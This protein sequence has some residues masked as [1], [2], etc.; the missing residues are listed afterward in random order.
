MKRYTLIF[1]F[2]IIAAVAILATAYS[3]DNADY[4]G[5][6]PAGYT[7]SPF[8][9]K[10]CS[11]C[12]GGTASNVT[13]WITSNVPGTGYVPGNNY[14]ITVTVSG[15]GNKGFEV[16]PQDVDG[17]L[18]GTLI[19]GPGTEL[20]GSGKYI[21]HSSDKNSDPA[22][23]TFTWT[24]PAAGTGEVVFYG[25]FALNLSVTKLSTLSVFESTVGI[26]DR[27]PGMIRG[28]VSPNPASGRFTL[29]L[30]DL[31]PGN[32]AVRIMNTTGNVVFSRQYQVSGSELSAP[33]DLSGQ[34]AGLYFIE[35][36]A[37]S[38][39]K[40]LKLILTGSE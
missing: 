4:P 34:A 29:A 18:L 24:A 26:S 1:G 2:G 11:T 5:G 12:H 32:L 33:V 15:N 7:G 23:W 3:G 8:D 21:T 22:V 30:A 37:G 13:G 40:T 31:V 6:A 25:A 28:S 9:G 17:N 19:V 36:R 10:N 27:N 35:T 20:T 14:T 39:V 38:S 16:S